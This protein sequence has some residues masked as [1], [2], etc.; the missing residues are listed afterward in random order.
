M[1]V[2]VAPPLVGAPAG[3]IEVGGRVG[4]ARRVAMCGRAVDA[5]PGRVRDHARIV[6]DEEKGQ[7]VL[8]L[9]ELE[10]VEDLGLDGGVEGRG[11]LV[12]DEEGGTADEGHGDHRALAE[13]SRQLEGV[14]VDLPGG[15]GKADRLEGLDGGVPSLGP[16]RPA[17]DLH[18]LGDLVPDGVDGREGGHR[19]LEDDRD[20]PASDGA[21]LAAVRVEAGQVHG[22][23]AIRGEADA[24]AL[25]PGARGEDPQDGLG[26]DALARSRLP[27][28]RHGLAPVESERDSVCRPHD[29]LVEVDVRAKI[30]DPEEGLAHA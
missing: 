8:L 23:P 18:R 10:E 20:R 28:D 7:A 14:G 25:E 4:N 9:E 16:A 21:H 12:G 3:A 2:E 24:P 30:L 17:V 19:L 11:R 26:D 29:P 1:I 6:G 13:T 15:V 22:G 5:V 27:H